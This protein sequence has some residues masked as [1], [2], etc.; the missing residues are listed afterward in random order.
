MNPACETPS[1]ACTMVPKR[2]ERGG[3]GGRKKIKGSFNI[4]KKQWLEVSRSWEFFKVG[5]K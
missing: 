3:R 1:D 2:E 5:R 4:F